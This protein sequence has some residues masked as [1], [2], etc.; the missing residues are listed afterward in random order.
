MS[1]HVLTVST[2]DIANSNDNDLSKWWTLFL[3]CAECLEQGQRL[4]NLSWR[5]SGRESSRQ[6]MQ[7]LEK[8]I[9]PGHLANLVDGIMTNDSLT[10][11]TTPI[12]SIPPPLSTQ[13][14]VTKENTHSVVHGFSRDHISSWKRS[15]HSSQQATSS[16][17]LI[18]DFVSTGRSC[19]HQERCDQDHSESAIEE[20]ED[21]S[22]YVEHGDMFQCVE[23]LTH[24]ALPSRHSL[25]STLLDQS[26]GAATATLQST[27]YPPT[28][29][30]RTTRRTMMSN[31]LKG[32]AGH[33]LKERMQ[34]R[35]FLE[36][37]LP[38]ASSN[39]FF[40]SHTVYHAK[41]W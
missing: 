14:A 41:G 26:S 1:S 38:D 19:L 23:V 12:Q 39:R 25:L 21:E 22:H 24:P 40:D 37:R 11:P 8:R 20:F 29:C 3:K 32:Y 30:R 13:P 15:Q 9:T 4:E 6:F 28:L 2:Y 33:L 10:H 16:N 27:L 18:I 36:N 7:A 31:E 5:L 34:N 17:I 35:G